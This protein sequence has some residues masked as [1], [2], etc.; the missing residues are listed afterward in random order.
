MARVHHH[1]ALGCIFPGGLR[2]EASP[3]ATPTPATLASFAALHLCENPPHVPPASAPAPVAIEETIQRVL[4]RLPRGRG[5]WGRG[6]ERGA[7]TEP[8]EE[9]PEASLMEEGGGGAGRN[10][11]EAPPQYARLPGQQ[12]GGNLFNKVVARCPL[13]GEAGVLQ[14]RTYALQQIRAVLHSTVLSLVYFPYWRCMFIIFPRHTSHSFDHS[15]SHSMGH[16]IDHSLARTSHCMQVMHSLTIVSCEIRLSINA[17]TQTSLTW[18]NFHVFSAPDKL[19]LPD[20]PRETVSNHT[21]GVTV[22]K[23]DLLTT[24]PFSHKVV[25]HDN[26]LGPL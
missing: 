13:L 26:V 11:R 25:Q 17:P 22:L 4:K 5:Q 20:C 7:D 14:K 6:Q 21:L 9:E 23:H 18:Y 8:C 3:L 19:V 2:R 24:S 12:Y 10:G 16:T 1:L 15:M